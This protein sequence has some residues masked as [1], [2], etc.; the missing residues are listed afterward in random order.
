MVCLQFPEFCKWESNFIHLKLAP[1][2][3]V[4]VKAF[5]DYTVQNRSLSESQLKK[6]QEKKNIYTFVSVSYELKS[7]KLEPA[8]RAD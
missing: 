2:V 7:M 3:S 6:P 4:L 1:S 8:Q 5:I